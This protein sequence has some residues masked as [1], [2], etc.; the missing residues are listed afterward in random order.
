M[1]EHPVPQI[2]EI[3][4]A[5]GKVLV[6]R[7]SIVVYFRIQQLLPSLIGWNTVGK[8]LDDPTPQGFIFQIGKLEGEHVT[9]ITFNAS[10]QLRQVIS[11]G[12]K[13]G[14]KIPPFDFDTAAGC[15][16]RRQVVKHD[17]WAD[18]DAGG[19]WATLQLQT[20]TYHYCHP[21]NHARQAK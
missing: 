21:Q 12:G 15:A 9:P 16:L 2:L 14:L 11:C 1:T 17:E 19:G 3:A 7:G 20:L 8:D 18:S 13:S 6:I 10:D 4:R 5:R